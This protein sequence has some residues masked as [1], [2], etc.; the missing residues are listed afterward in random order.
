MSN[1]LLLSSSLDHLNMMEEM[2]KSRMNVNYSSM[3]CR[4]AI[5]RRTLLGGLGD[6]KSHTLLGG[7]YMTRQ[8]QFGPNKSVM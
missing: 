5:S 6:V 1:T 8:N 2:I 3:S 7:N 4:P